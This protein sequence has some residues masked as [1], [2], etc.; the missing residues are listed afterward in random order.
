[1]TWPI[2]SFKFI[3]RGVVGSEGPHPPATRGIA[4]P[5]YTWRAAARSSSSRVLR[6]P[7]PPQHAGLLFLSIPS[8]PLA[9]FSWS[10]ASGNLLLYEER[11]RQ[12]QQ[13]NI[14]S[15]SANNSVYCPYPRGQPHNVFQY[16]QSVTGVRQ[17]Q[18][19]AWSRKTALPCT[20]KANWCGRQCN[21]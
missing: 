9:F 17:P 6:G 8:A 18:P 13:V 3:F 7:T 15:D 16:P 20:C 2:K 5:V 14:V 19:P 10:R 21:G 1:M 12:P 11:G 4:I